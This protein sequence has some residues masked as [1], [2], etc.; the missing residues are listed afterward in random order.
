VAKKYYTRRIPSQRKLFNKIN[1]KEVHNIT[2]RVGK[3]VNVIVPIR[4][5]NKEND[6]F[7]TTGI[8]LNG[9]E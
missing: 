7:I 9:G 4:K 3:S 8:S 2:R 5:R 6:I 1:V